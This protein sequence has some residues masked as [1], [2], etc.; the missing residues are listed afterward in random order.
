MASQCR[1]PETHLGLR[2]ILRFNGLSIGMVQH[3]ASVLLMDGPLHK[4]K[5]QVSRDIHFLSF[6]IVEVLKTIAQTNTSLFQSFFGNGWDQVEFYHV[7]NYLL[8][9]LASLEES[10]SDSGSSDGGREG[11]KPTS[12]SSDNKIEASKADLRDSLIELIGYYCS[13]NQHNQV[14]TGTSPGSA[15]GGVGRV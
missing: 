4:S 7:T 2:G 12:S 11:P 13:N 14:R 9:H 8:T 10:D 1:F 15:N 5:K 3:L 6:G